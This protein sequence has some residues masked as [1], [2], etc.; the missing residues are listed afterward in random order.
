MNDKIDLVEK[1]VDTLLRS[2]NE[3]IECNELDYPVEMYLN[4]KLE[5]L[6]MIKQHINTIN[7][8]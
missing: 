2:N 6:E 4:G 8:K 1:L 5:M 3:F 7:G